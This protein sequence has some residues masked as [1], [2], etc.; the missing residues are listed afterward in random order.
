[1]SRQN[2][3]R[4]D[5][6]LE[7][8]NV[9]T[10]KGEEETQIEQS[11][12]IEIETNKKCQKASNS[13]SS[14][15]INNLTNYSFGFSENILNSEEKENDINNESKMDIIGS[16]KKTKNNITQK[17]R[18][19]D[20]VVKIKLTKMKKPK[21]VESSGKETPNFRLKNKDDVNLSDKE[22]DNLI[23]ISSVTKDQNNE[24]N[25][26]ELDLLEIKEE[27]KENKKEEK[28]KESNM[29]ESIHE[30]I[31]NFCSENIECDK[32][33]KEDLDFNDIIQKE[34]KDISTDM[35]IEPE[36]TE[37]STQ[38]KEDKEI[39]TSQKKEDN[40]I[41][42]I[43][44]MN[45]ETEPNKEEKKND[46]IIEINEKEYSENLVNLLDENCEEN[47]EGKEDKKE[48]KNKKKKLTVK[49]SIVE[50]NKRMTIEDINV[51]DKTK[52]E[53]IDNGDN[54]GKNEEQIQAEFQPLLVEESNEEMNNVGN[55]NN[56]NKVEE[57]K[58]EKEED[59]KIKEKDLQEENEKEEIKVL[60]DSKNLLEEGKK[61]EEKDKMKKDEEEEEKEKKIN[62]EQDNVK[63]SGIKESRDNTNINN[64]FFGNM[65]NNFG[66]DFIEIIKQQ[67][68]NELRQEMLKK[69]D[70][71]N[72]HEPLYQKEN[73]NPEK[74]INSNFLGKKRLNSPP[75]KIYD[76]E[77]DKEKIIEKETNV[78]NNNN[79]NSND[80]NKESKE[81]KQGKEN[82]QINK[83]NDINLEKTS[84]VYELLEKYIF[85]YLYEKVMKESL[86]NNNELEK[87]LKMLIADKGY[88]NVK[89][90]L[91]NIKKENDKKD[92][93][94]NSI[95]SKEEPNEYHYRFE[96]NFC[97]RFKSIKSN[98]GFQTYICCDQKCKA[99]GKL[100]IKER[101]FNIIENHSVHLKE[102]INF[103]ED[104]PAYFMKTRKL[105]E[106]HIKR[107]DYN[108]KYHL[109]WFK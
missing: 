25:K 6:D 67:I 85:N 71:K 105:D 18:K 14:I 60:N 5:Y 27:N 32:K 29:E 79:D 101:K 93:E 63:A 57:K 40:I 72:S 19:C 17:S 8:S 10:L 55:N 7:A 96:N 70:V 99:Y 89:S 3:E 39:I 69:E 44:Q 1:M 37:I 58:E 52:E 92:N 50:E 43:A 76:I 73:Q 62:K 94:N 30:D 74:D 4:Y 97:H 35:I 28:E 56:G 11:S 9:F 26:I 51:K 59:E 41:K 23:E 53:E 100:N 80:N 38:E 45:L 78:I 95:K 49:E 88:S 64:N 84:S 81:K 24:R 13:H 98:D 103:N 109:E 107:N 75:K 90:S 12:K 33:I 83:E 46:I 16:F 2:S 91:I 86:S 47:K 106:V 104:R 66:L 20:S 48:E 42:E 77:K 31:E 87:Q 108:D 61:N 82:Q 54:K 22:M 34:N 36:K 21:F 102:H 68:K 15:I 65:N